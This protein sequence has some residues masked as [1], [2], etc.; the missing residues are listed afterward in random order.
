VPAICEADIRAVMSH[1]LC[2]KLLDKPG[3]MQDPV[4]ETV[5]NTFIG[6]HCV[7]ATRLNGLDQ[8]RARFILR[9]HSESN[10]GVSLQVLWEPGQKVTVMQFADPGEI[11]LGEGEV[12][13][14][15]DTPP[16]GGCRTSVELAIDGPADVRDTRG[17]HQLFIYGDHKRDFEAYGQMFGIKTAHI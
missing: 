6:A 5:R 3:F 7:C 1:T 14:N 12:L 8:P 11:I 9:S 4:P 10:L 13:K 15:H 2:L 17:F 16:A